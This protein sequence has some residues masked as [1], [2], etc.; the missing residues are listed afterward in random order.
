MELLEDKSIETLS[1]NVTAH[2]EASFF[3]FFFLSFFSS[4]LLSEMTLKKRN[5]ILKRVLLRCTE[6][7]VVYLLSCCFKVVDE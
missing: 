6:N 1:S 3:L 7:F 5:Q 4:D 2:N